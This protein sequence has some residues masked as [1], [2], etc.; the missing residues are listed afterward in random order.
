[1]MDGILVFRMT[2]C[3]INA[4]K[5]WNHDKVSEVIT[6]SG[7]TV[8]LPL[9]EGVVTLVPGVVFRTTRS[10]SGGL[11]RLRVFKYYCHV[12]HLI[13]RLR[14]RNAR[15]FAG[16]VGWSEYVTVSGQPR[17]ESALW[18]RVLIVTFR[19]GKR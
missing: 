3:N 9:T 19:F 17:S 12:F 11:R 2:A 8:Y 10:F 1:M 15:F 14:K 5:F 4:V 18:R 7:R 13:S 6:P 16:G